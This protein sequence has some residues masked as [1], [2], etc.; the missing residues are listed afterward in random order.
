MYLAVFFSYFT[1]YI[2]LIIV[3]L[4]SVGGFVLQAVDHYR[5]TNGKQPLSR[6][7][8]IV[9]ACLGAFGSLMGMLL[10][11]NRLRDRMLLLLSIGFVVLLILLTLFL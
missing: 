2:F 4:L 5:V 6:G 10:F 1:N 7:L 11:Q 9:G 8:L 3:G